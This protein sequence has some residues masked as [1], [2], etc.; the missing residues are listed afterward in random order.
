MDIAILGYG[1]VGSG[2][3]EVIRKNGQSIATRAGEPIRVKK[4]LDIRDFP[5]SPDRELFTKDPEEIFGDPDI[6]V[7]AETIGGTRAAQ[8]FTKRAF[9]AG[10][11]VV[12]S[13]KELVASHGPELLKMAEENG[14]NYLFEA[15]VGGGIPI[16]RPLGQCLAANVINGITGILN[17][18][19][20]Y[21]LTKMRKEGMDFGDALKGAQQNGYAEADPTADVEGHDACRKIAILSSIAYNE[22]VDCSKIHTEGITRIS[23]ADMQYAE[24]MDS[25]IKLIGMSRKQGDRIFA[26]VTP[27]IISKEHPLANVEDVFNAIVV[28]GDAIGDAM[29]YGRGAGKLPTASAVIADIIDIAMHKERTSSVWER[30]DGDNL[31]PF[32]ESESAFFVRVS[33]RSMSEARKFIVS[34]FDNV[35]YIKPENMNNDSELA[36]RTRKMTEEVFADCIARLR[37]IASVKE[38]VNVVRILE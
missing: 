33:V 25:V 11:H 26:R 13:N 6:K 5:E 34:V 22:F 1:V 19:T 38:I 28:S 30:K 4:I 15:S 20:N 37:G 32:G 9:A 36:F 8:E 7:V 2:V 29:F 10:K 12:T 35:E 18:T 3:A 23:P 17:G 14:V 24:A 27:A 31:V 21:I 16:I